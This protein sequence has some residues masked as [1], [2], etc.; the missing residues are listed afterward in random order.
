MPVIDLALARSHLRDP[1]DDDAYLG[2]LLEAAEDQAMQFMDR[3]FY[4]SQDDLDA[5][6]AAGEAGDRPLVINDSIRAACL[7]I[8]GHLYGN[9]EDVVIGTI[10]TAIPQGSRVLM[11]PYRIGM[12]I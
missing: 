12:G 6:V 10:A 4:S 11:T 8:L 5:A 2:M 9:R 1:D 7:L 3:R